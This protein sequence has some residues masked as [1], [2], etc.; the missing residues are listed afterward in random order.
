MK[1][2]Y[3]G[4]GRGRFILEGLVECLRRELLWL[5][6]VGGAVYDH[7]RDENVPAVKI[8]SQYYGRDMGLTQAEAILAETDSQIE[9]D[10]A[11]L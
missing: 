6:A 5:V 11:G 4:R 3:S 1:R 9:R 10:L 2:W 7:C 8:Y